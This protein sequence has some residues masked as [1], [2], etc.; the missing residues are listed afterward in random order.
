MGIKVLSKKEVVVITL[1]VLVLIVAFCVGRINQKDERITPITLAEPP[2][3][4]SEAEQKLFH[5]IR[6]HMVNPEGGIYTNYLDNSDKTKGHAVLSE[7]VG[8]LLK[9][10]VSS[11]NEELFIQQLNLLQHRFV[12]GDFIAWIYPSTSHHTVN[13]SVDDL[14]IIE[15]LWDGARIFNNE[16]AFNLGLRLA[17]GLLAT[18]TDGKWLFDYADEKKRQVAPTVQVRYANLSAL[19]KLAEKIPEYL[20]IYEQMKRILEQAEQPNGLYA[21]AYLP[22]ESRYVQDPALLTTAVS[23]NMSEQIITALY[24]EQA[25]IPTDSM[26]KRLADS[27]QKTGKLFATADKQSGKMKTDMESPAVYALAAML[28]IESD[29]IS[30]ARQCLTRLEELQVSSQSY[31]DAPADIRQKAVQFEGGYLDVYRLQAFSFDQLE[32]LLAMRIGGGKSE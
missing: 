13:S 2:T 7:S 28:F 14:R 8:L 3:Y 6:T 12:E 16:Q 19:Q 32:S 15:A 27:L 25:G 30:L 29:Q 31:Q 20:P 9:Y 26:R 18:N 4:G 17:K 22:K 1:V 11:H 5:F 10:A 21:L 24:A 23:T